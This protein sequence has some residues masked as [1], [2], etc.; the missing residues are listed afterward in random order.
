MHIPSRR[1]IWLFVEIVIFT[2][3]VAFLMIVILLYW[4]DNAV[5][6]IYQ[7]SYSDVQFL[8][9]GPNAG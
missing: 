9:T 2:L 1:D 6:W 3:V 4:R 5:Q 7:P 8:R